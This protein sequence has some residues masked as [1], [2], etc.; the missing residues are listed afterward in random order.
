MARPMRPHRWKPLGPPPGWNGLVASIDLS[1][2]TDDV[3]FLRNEK[4]YS[5]SWW[6][7]GRS[8]VECK[9]CEPHKKKASLKRV[10]G[11]R[12]YLD[13]VWGNPLASFD[14]PTCQ[15]LSV[16]CHHQGF[17]RSKPLTWKTGIVVRNDEPKYW[18]GQV[19]RPSTAVVYR[20]QS[21][22]ESTLNH[23][24][25]KGCIAFGMFDCSSGI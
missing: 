3:F 24:P 15:V 9:S 22:N 25:G 23:Y 11:Q 20:Q 2:H 17:F 19:S 7:N 4:K 12:C 13:R 8:S 1:C 5:I 14:K 16:S 18:T 10:F 6:R 21:G